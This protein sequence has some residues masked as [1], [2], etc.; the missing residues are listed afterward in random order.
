MLLLFDKTIVLQCLNSF[1][2]FCVVFCD[3]LLATTTTK[4]YAS[5]IHITHSY[6]CKFLLIQI[7]I[8][9][10]NLQDQAALTEQGKVLNRGFQS[11]SF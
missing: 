9:Y 5:S 3:V 2:F 11:V 4:N 1:Q 7:L 10:L 6:Y 8:L